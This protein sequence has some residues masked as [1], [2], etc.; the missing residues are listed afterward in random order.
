MS[1]RTRSAVA[2]AASLMLTGS[3]FAQADPQP[4]DQGLSNQPAQPGLLGGAPSDRPDGVNRPGQDRAADRVAQPG[5]TGQAAGD[6]WQQQLQKIAQSKEMAAEKLFVLE[7]GL[8]SAFE[9]QLSELAQRK[10]QND[11]VKQLA[12]QI[13]QDHRQASQRLQPIAQKHQIEL[14]QALPQMKQT[15][16]QIFEAM[17]PEVFDK[18]YVKC[19]DA[20]HAHDVTSFRHAAQSAQAPDVK[21]FAGETLPKLQ[22]HHQQTRQVASALGMEAGDMAQPAGGRLPGSTTPD[23]RTPDRRTPGAEPR[24]QPDHGS[25]NVDRE[26]PD[27]VRPQPGQ[28]RPGE[29]PPPR[30]Q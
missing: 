16:L 8:G 6:Q 3:C 5:R 14:P 2:F 21:Q 22:Q 17:D 12:A 26:R 4:R 7:A 24:P 23:S 30:P 29:V 1:Y 11:Q 28:D 25:P 19:M 15:K 18:A 20:A 10:S 27:S 9:I 13:I